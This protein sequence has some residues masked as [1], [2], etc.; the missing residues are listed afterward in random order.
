MTYR[1]ELQPSGNNFEVEDGQNIL[2][3]ALAAGYQL[4]YSCRRGTCAT[5]RC[6]IISGEVDFGEY[7]EAMLPPDMKADGYVLLCQAT[8]LSDV[9]LEAHE[10]K[11]E[12]Q[13]PR[14]IPC[15][16]RAMERPADGIAIIHLRLPQ[17]EEF[18]HVAGQYIDIMLKGGKRRA[19][20]IANKPSVH[21]VIDIELHVR[22]SP[23]GLF[24]DHVF[25]GMKER[26]LLRFEGPLGTLFLRE[27]SDKPIIFLA[28]G[29]GF[30]PIKALIEHA[31]SK[32]MKRKMTLYWGG[33]R[34]HDIY[35]SDLAERWA[36]EH[37]TFSFVPVVSEACSADNWDGRSGLVHRAVMEDF[38][39][40]SGHQVYACGNPDMIDAARAE[41]AEANRLPKG[42]FFADP[43][44]DEYERSK[45]SA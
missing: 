37:D 18:R 15:R 25:S 9:T 26:E 41:F 17:N 11:L 10:L 6:R 19:Y 24:T 5:C 7:V 1:I 44:I 38:P 2:N 42:E 35:M 34:P 3:A 39:D 45:E 40:L 14:V 27:D 12:A 36:D 31:V 20:S 22:H 21:G 4:A 23:G 43:F 8:A 13:K 28:S 30:A 29:T 32:G 33:R 16:V